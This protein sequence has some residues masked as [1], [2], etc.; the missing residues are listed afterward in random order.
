MIWQI[1]DSILLLSEYYFTSA[2]SPRNTLAKPPLASYIGMQI[3][4]NDAT[5]TQTMAILT[6]K[7]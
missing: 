7:E 3:M 5:D 2:F 6:Q 1:Y 4:A